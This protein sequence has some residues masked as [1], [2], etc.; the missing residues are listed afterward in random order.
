M[1]PPFLIASHSLTHCVEWNAR[2]E[3]LV[4]KFNVAQ[5]NRATEKIAKARRD[6]YLEEQ[7]RDALL[8]GAKLED[9]SD[10]DS[11]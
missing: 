2:R 9:T 5:R 6:S 3:E 10:S 7:R 8:I 1:P 11:D 4:A